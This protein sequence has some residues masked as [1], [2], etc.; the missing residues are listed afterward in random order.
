MSF[1]Y[2]NF[3]QCRNT[4]RDSKEEPDIFGTL[5]EQFNILQRELVN[6]NKWADSLDA[7]VKSCLP[8]MENTFYISMPAFE[9]KI[10][11][12]RTDK[13]LNVALR[14]EKNVALSYVVPDNKDVIFIGDI[15][16]GSTVI[17]F[18]VK[19][20]V[21][22][23]SNVSK[24]GEMIVRCTPAVALT[25]RL[26]GTNNL[27]YYGVS[28]L[29]DPILTRDFLLQLCENV[30]PLRDPSK[31]VVFF[32]KWDKY[33]SFR[34]Y[35]LTEQRKRH[36]AISDYSVRLAYTVKKS[37][38][39]SDESLK[40]HILDGFGL[41][42]FS[43]NEKIVID[44]E[45]D[46]AEEL[47]LL[48]V[49]F[50]I[51]KEQM[52]QAKRKRGRR[53]TTVFESELYNLT[54]NSVV[55]SHDSD[56]RF[57]TDCYIADERYKIRKKDVLPDC[58][59]IV[60]K[61]EG[62]KNEQIAEIKSKYDA[63]IRTKSME[64]KKELHDEYVRRAT[65]NIEAY[66]VQ[67]SALIETERINNSDENIRK[68][69]ELEIK[70]LSDSI[71]SKCRKT[72]SELNK[73]ISDLKRSIYKKER[74]IVSLRKKQEA[75]IDSI[76][77]AG[78]ESAL[79]LNKELQQVEESIASITAVIMQ[80]NSEW[81]SLS[82]CKDDLRI[83]IEAEKKAA[84]GSVDINK[85]YD[86]K[87]QQLLKAKETAE[88]SNIE[89]LENQQYEQWYEEIKAGYHLNI[90]EEI[91]EITDKLYA[92]RDYVIAE[93]LR[94]ETETVFYV[95]FKLGVD[96]DIKK[97]EKELGK[98]DPKYILFDIR[99]EQA[100][101]NRQK[102][103]LFLLKNGYVKNPYLASYLFEPELLD[104]EVSHNISEP[105]WF[106]SRLND[107]QKEAVIKALSSDSLFLLQGPPGTG[108][109]EVIA[110][111][112]A[113]MAKRGNKILI[114]SETHKAIDNVFD[115]LP[116]ISEI[117]PIRLIPSNS[118][119]KSRYSID[120]LLENF[121]K[122]ITDRL[123]IQITKYDNF[124]ELKDSF[125][126][127]MQEL[128][129]LYQKVINL[130]KHTAQLQ[131]QKTEL[132]AQRQHA[133]DNII[134]CRNEKN[135]IDNDIEA[136]EI[137]R[138]TISGL[139]EKF[140]EEDDVKASQFFNE[141]KM[142][143]CDYPCLIRAENVLREA[144]QFDLELAR[145]ELTSM[146]HS[147]SEELLKLKLKKS[148]LRDKINE[149]QDPD[150]M[151]VYEGR[152]AEEKALK[153]EFKA[154]NDKIKALQSNTG[155]VD[156]S[157]LQLSEIIQPKHLN[158]L[159]QHNA[160][161]QA[162]TDIKSSVGQLIETYIS[163]TEK[164]LDEL[165]KQKVQLNADILDT[166]A[167]IQEINVKIAD[168]DEHSDF[169]EYQD[170]VTNLSMQIRLFFAEFNINEEFSPGDFRAAIMIVKRSWDT[171]EE[172]Y[173]RQ[174]QEN[175]IKIPMFKSICSYLNT[176]IDEDE[177]KQYTK[178]LFDNANV[179]GMTCT[180]NSKFGQN[181]DNLAQY[182]IPD[183]Y[184]DKMGIDVVIVDE[185]SKSAFLDLL[186][187]ILYG[188]TV[189]LVGDH[190]QLHPMYDLVHMRKEDF[191]ML[192]SDKINEATNKEY[193]AMMQECYFKTLF[194]KTPYSN[195]I[196]LNKQY[197][198]H[199]DIMDTF[200]HFYGGAVN[201]LSIGTANQNELKKHDLSYRLNGRTIF[202]ASRH[203]Y[204]VD[205]E[206][207]EQMLEG[208]TSIHNV[209]EAD[210]VAKLLSYLDTACGERN[211]RVNALNHRKNDKLSVGVI[212]TY[213]D[214]AREIKNRIK[215]TKL[216]N[217]GNFSND[218]E[219]KLVVSTVDDFQG[220]ERDIIIVSMVRNPIDR[221]RTAEFISQFER[222]NVAFSRARK[223][224]IIVGSKDFLANTSI[225]LPDINGNH[226]LDKR[227]FR[228]YN[229]I[230]NT[231][232]A[233]GIV[234]SADDVLGGK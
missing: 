46:G 25:T 136:I 188:K 32:D 130:K 169:V 20:I 55:M 202:D 99:A 193:A 137:Y 82:A 42:S 5:E 101:I 172:N 190:R 50:R 211:S 185:V 69:V 214:Q 8:P 195:K 14:P 3:V 29:R 178:V 127:K 231:I 34:D 198:C 154:V 6:S 181:I 229:E 138:R 230:I 24:R 52:E 7:F 223:M 105:E 36:I 31:S 64:K 128:K 100:K 93:K 96:T 88:K 207:N 184:M 180:A 163:P 28:D 109:T 155:S 73:K 119:K 15:I 72:I 143:A 54:R 167:S 152:E 80:K 191:E 43:R 189:I 213:G 113:Q 67:L 145:K 203:I 103:A 170:K 81:E 58:S 147:E 153:L 116:K 199:S 98:I 1:L 150:T 164:Q 41:N 66:K 62:I 115:R 89:V 186:I 18:S 129:A 23:D 173:A 212:C 39:V 35:Y 144:Y 227:N 196:M 216:R 161:L 75:L 197:R 140:V 162:L 175:D 70:K 132:E 141:V 125:S 117:R 176:E 49:T 111:I 4:V 102:R 142:V 215:N 106:S 200:N 65:E 171:L 220:D 131:A 179:F 228:V 226:K 22:M 122:N 194:E 11:E 165:K 134:S 133:N 158:D 218:P 209:Q 219:E 210:V 40:Q 2:M 118:H 12:G 146:A 159:S 104:G 182:G 156:T 205:C 234:L 232:S 85:Y 48:T 74:E 83:K 77:K 110:E 95:Y 224:L 121:Y 86:A 206:Q 17:A 27:P 124:N 120:D 92:D 177:K 44:K 151:D 47:P 233:K 37:A 112:C 157:T 38:F 9:R 217:S 168:I 222:I 174:K 68:S 16:L 57:F 148:E 10:K 204:F 114:S 135:R 108:K 87:Y 208:S 97:V 79:L 123:Q 26:V 76:T 166:E 160:I 30:Y 33:I 59:E 61:Y 13:I 63:L 139:D 60:E 90:V 183:I 91:K 221:R 201:G 126:E 192:D 56:T 78:E 45:I 94:H 84:A 225:T 21:L 19:G 71:D 107:T 53:E 187:P 51:N 149:L